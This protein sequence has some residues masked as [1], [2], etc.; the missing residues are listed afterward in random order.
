V[1]KT[2]P[3]FLART[4]SRWSLASAEGRALVRPTGLADPSI[5]RKSRGVSVPLCAPLRVMQSRKGDGETT[6]E[7]LPL[8]ASTQLRP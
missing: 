2:A 8:V 5:V 7:K 1:C 4:I 3:A 6:A